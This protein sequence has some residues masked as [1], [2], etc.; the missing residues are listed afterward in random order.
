MPVDNLD[1]YRFAINKRARP[2]SE[3][4]RPTKCLVDAGAEAPLKTSHPTTTD[5]GEFPG[6]IGLNIYF[7]CI[8]SGSLEVSPTSGITA[9]L[10]A[11]PFDFLRGAEAAM[12]ADTECVV[13]HL[14]GGQI[15]I[16]QVRNV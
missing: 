14:T 9:R 7:D 3:I 1:R 12:L 13:I 4:H 10:G 15:L 16:M 8:F 5:A 6:L 11:L 2:Q